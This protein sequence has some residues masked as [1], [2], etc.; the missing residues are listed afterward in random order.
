VVAVW[1]DPAVQRFVTTYSRWI[2][3]PEERIEY[4]GTPAYHFRLI[5]LTS[6]A[7]LHIFADASTL[8]V[9]ATFED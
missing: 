7:Q 3:P 9:R 4:A 6:A 5:D 2:S 8:Q 1:L